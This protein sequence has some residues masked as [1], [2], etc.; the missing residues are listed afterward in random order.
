[1]DLLTEQAVALVSVIGVDSA[2][3]VYVT[4]NDAVRKI[5]RQLWS[6]P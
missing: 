2:S 5:T 6:R 3:N 4:D 1:M